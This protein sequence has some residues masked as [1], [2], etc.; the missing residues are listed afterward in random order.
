VKP[1]RAGGGWRDSCIG[2]CRGSYGM[3]HLGERMEQRNDDRAQIR[4][5]I[6]EVTRAS[7][8]TEDL[9]VYLSA[10][11][12]IA[13]YPNPLQGAEGRV[14][15]VTVV[16]EGDN[17]PAPGDALRG[18]IQAISPDRWRAIPGEWTVEPAPHEY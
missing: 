13:G 15:R 3:I 10:V 11:E 5:R 14:I 12:S 9:T 18:R 7:D 16:L 8:A 17:R 1:R 2:S 4:G 6:E